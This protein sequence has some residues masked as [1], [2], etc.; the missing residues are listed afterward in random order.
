MELEVHAR[1][2]KNLD[3]RQIEF[4]NLD[5]SLNSLKLGAF[6][7]KVLQKWVKPYFGLLK[8]ESPILYSLLFETN[9]FFQ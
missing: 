3:F 8:C 5:I 4:Q 1:F 2:F 6:R 9:F 7:W